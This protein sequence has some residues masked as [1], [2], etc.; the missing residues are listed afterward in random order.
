MIQ[1]DVEQLKQAIISSHH[2]NCPARTTPSPRKVP[3][4]NKKLSGLRAK[5]RRLFNI[6]N[7]TEH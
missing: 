7:R 1:D 2:S 3:W 5:T 4:R 6:A